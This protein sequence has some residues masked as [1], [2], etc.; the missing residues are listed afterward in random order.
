MRIN[1][2]VEFEWNGEEYVVVDRDSYEYDGAVAHAGGG[3][4]STPDYQ[5]AA[6]AQ[7]ESS[8]EVT[9]MQNYANRPD[10]NTPWGS[11]SW[12]SAAQV[13]PATGQN[14]TKWTQNQTLNPWAQGALDSQLQL[15]NQRSGLGQNFMSRV[16]QD[17]SQPF[18][19]NNLP[20]TGQNIA[21]QNTDAGQTQGNVQG[22]PMQYGVQ[23]YQLN[24]QGPQQTTGSTN[25]M[26]FSQDRNRIEQSL[27]D[28]MRPEHQ[29]QDEALRTRLANQGL[30]SGSTA[31]N[32][33]MNQQAQS[34]AGE[35]FNAMNAAGAEQSRLQAG[36]LGQQQQ[37][38]GQ[39]SASRQQGNAALGQQFGQGLQAGNFWNQVQGQGFGQGMQN[40]GLFNQAGQ[41]NF[42]QNLGANAQNFSQ[43]MQASQYQNQLRQQAIAEQAQRRGMSLNEMNAM[44]TGQQV[45]T[46][47]MPTFNPAQAAQPVNYL[48]AAQM[49]GQA[50]Q[51]ADAGFGSLLGTA[52]NVGMQMYGA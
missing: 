50:N 47:N 45:Q 6:Q 23:G 27:F 1:T 20:S 35:R 4:G 9:N 39:D 46:P 14:V 44:L 18:D 37:A 48:G 11:T 5:G 19:W 22:R 29:F 30:S 38:F 24:T 10:Q 17:F 36:L 41:Q 42:A 7:G 3:K 28:R 13:D 16:G 31:Y 40:A 8:K 26:G 51:A 15:Q 2:R 49:Q 12:Q 25:E 52:A 21:A 32:R 43:N 34:Q 33:A